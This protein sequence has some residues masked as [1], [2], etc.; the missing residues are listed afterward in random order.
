MRKEAENFLKFSIP[1]CLQLLTNIGQR[2]DEATAC[3]ERLST[4]A[5][6]VTTAFTNWGST[7]YSLEDEMSISDEINRLL[8]SDGS[9]TWDQAPQENAYLGFGVSSLSFENL[10]SS[11]LEFFEWNPEWDIMPAEST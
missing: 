7:L 6:N 9:L 11:D 1:Q 5:G 4:L 3:A 10:P 2:W 8:F